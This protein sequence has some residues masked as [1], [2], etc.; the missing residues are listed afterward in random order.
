M[1]VPIVH[2]GFILG[3]ICGFGFAPRDPANDPACMSLSVIHQLRCVAS[4]VANEFR[5]IEINAV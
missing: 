1:G 4:L 2:N 3:A 5:K